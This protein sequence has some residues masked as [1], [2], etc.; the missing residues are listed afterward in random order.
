MDKLICRNE[1]SGILKWISQFILKIHLQ[2]CLCIY[3]IRCEQNNNLMQGSLFKQSERKL[4]SLRPYN[5][6]RVIPAQG[7]ILVDYTELTGRYSFGG[8]LLFYFLFKEHAK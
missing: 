6:I 7:V 8:Y 4:V 2:Y 1:Q 5:L 3:I